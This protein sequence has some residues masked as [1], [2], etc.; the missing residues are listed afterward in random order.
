M[1][2]NLTINA[3]ALISMITDLRAQG[4]ASTDSEAINVLLRELYDCRR[5]KQQQIQ[6]EQVDTETSDATPEMPPD[7]SERLTF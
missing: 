1:K 7:E 2:I 5:Q 3:P 6:H 4:L